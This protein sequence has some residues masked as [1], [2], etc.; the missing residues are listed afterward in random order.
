MEDNLHSEETQA[1]YL[2][3][4]YQQNFIVICIEAELLRCL[5]CLHFHDNAVA[6]Q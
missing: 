3:L 5:S 4:L 1:Y 2:L 6:I